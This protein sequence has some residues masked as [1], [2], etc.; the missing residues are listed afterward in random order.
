MR[1][2]TAATATSQSFIVYIFNAAEA[3]RPLS[4]D[5]IQNAHQILMNELYTDD[6]VPLKINAGEYR[7]YV[8][9]DGG[10]HTY[11]DFSSVPSTVVR[12][13]REYI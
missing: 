12:I 9:G 5:L 13:V 6:K 4:E 11:P 3:K 1:K 2:R 7:R 10:M 8:V